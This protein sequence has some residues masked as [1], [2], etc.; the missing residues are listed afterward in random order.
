MLKY[1]FVGRGAE[2]L[3]VHPVTW[4]TFQLMEQDIR[5]GTGWSSAL[6]RSSPSDGRK[7]LESCGG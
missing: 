7:S 1:L 4:G 6:T 2:S 5:W 3:S